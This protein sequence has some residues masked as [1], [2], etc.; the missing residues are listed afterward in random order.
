VIP[1][2]RY[3]TREVAHSLRWIAPVLLF[4]VAQ[5]VLATGDGGVLST[6]AMSATVLFFSATWLTVVA[7]NVEPPAQEDITVVTV[8]SRA[9]VRLAKLLVAYTG[10]LALD[11]VGLVVPAAVAPVA[12]TPTQL[13]V[14]A[15]SQAATA[16]LGM[17]V[18][19]LCSRPLVRHTA[20]AVLLGVTVGLA[21]VVV[22][23]GPPIRQLLDLL[24]EPNPRDLL[25]LVAAVTAETSV[26]AAVAVLSS[27]RV[28]RAQA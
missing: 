21:D 22:P 4:A 26:L 16:L 15:L 14:G 12:P 28:P 2:C 3:V 1:L 8:G 25:L 11:I 19:A 24:N 9:R 23:N 13:A 6:Y 20:W 10:C 5:A 7:C 18:G 27:L 17:G